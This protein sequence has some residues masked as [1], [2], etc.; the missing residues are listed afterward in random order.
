[1]ETFISAAPEK[2]NS[3]SRVAPP[4]IFHERAQ[5][6]ESLASGQSGFQRASRADTA[7][8]S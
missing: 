2:E 5:P 6:S 7:G 8:Q 1:M 3:V 4:G